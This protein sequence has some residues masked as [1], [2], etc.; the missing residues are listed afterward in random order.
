MAKIRM[1]VRYTGAGWEVTST[2]RRKLPASKPYQTREE[3]LSDAFF[4][5]R[6]LRAM[7]DEVSVF[8]ESSHG[9][10]EAIDD[11]GQ[12]VFLKH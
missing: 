11:T 2:P 9:M 12:Q 6:M 4:A 1:M 7:G 10:I 8:V 3:A 5:C